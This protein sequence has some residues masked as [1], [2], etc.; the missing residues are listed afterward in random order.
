MFE[1]VRYISC[2]KFISSSEWIHQDRVIDSYEMIFVTKGF[3]YINENGCDYALQA[4]DAII[5][6]PGVRHYGYQ[7]STDTEFFWVHWQ[8]DAAFSLDIKHRKIED[9]YSIS[10]YF[11]QLL[12]CRIEGKPAECF[13]YLARLILA[14]LHFNSSNPNVNHTA[15]T[16]AAWIKANRHTAIKAAQVA[17]YFG[18]N[19]DYLNKMF[20]ASF[21]KSI[22]EYIDDE[23][24]KYIKAMMLSQNLSLNE[25]AVQA[26]FTDYKYFL[27]FFKYHEGITPTQFYKENAKVYIN[28][29]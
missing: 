29:R 19:V 17:A 5:L 26:G 14:E 13:D 6:Q 18:Y 21:L 22:K 11:R 24:M 12:Q 4:D 28:T 16:V 25:V 8:S 1:T 9:P 23:R 2:G 20:K 15:E 27:K 3:V 10:L 7:S